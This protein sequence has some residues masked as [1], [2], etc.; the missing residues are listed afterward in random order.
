MTKEQR[1]RLARIKARTATAVATAH[2][3]IFSSGFGN[4]GRR[5]GV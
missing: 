1:E 2:P 5:S 4:T 3:S